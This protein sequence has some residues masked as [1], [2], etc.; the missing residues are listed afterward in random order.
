MASRTVNLSEDAYQGLAS[1]KREGES[2]S[3]VVNRLTGKHA[4]R[5]VYGILAPAQGKA[6]SRAVK[7]SR[8]R[9]DADF[10]KRRVRL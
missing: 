6:L 8:A 2:F 5:H 3:D 4:I 7:S 9:I 10:A 1:L